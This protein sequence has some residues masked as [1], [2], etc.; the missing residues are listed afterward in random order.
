MLLK[1]A[2]MKNIILTTLLLIGFG[3]SSI[4]QN[5]PVAITISAQGQTIAVYLDSNNSTKTLVLT[6]E[7]NSEAR[8]VIIN[9]NAKK[10]AAYRRKYM[11]SGSKNKTI[12]VAFAGRVAGSNFALLDSIF[13]NTQKG[14]IYRLYTVAIPRNGV[15]A[16]K[17][18]KVLLC[19]VVVK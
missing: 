17:A 11:L 4:G 2:T 16:A 13:S 6:N 8:L 18:K 3:M 15:E 7:K 5:N 12:N 10:D 19:N 14:K 1:N 9:P